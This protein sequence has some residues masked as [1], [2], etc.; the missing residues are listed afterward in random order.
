MDSTAGIWAFGAYLPRSRLERTAIAAATRWA[1]GARGGKA[2]GARSCC[3]WDEDSVT[4][5]VEAARDCL[6]GRGRGS[7]GS[8]T[9]A[10]TTLP[11]ADRSNAGIVAT[12]L[13]LD[14]STAVADVASCQR[15]GTSALLEALQRPGSAGDAL[16]LASDRRLARPGSDQEMNYGH[17]AAALLVG[18]GPGLLAE[19]LGH[20]TTMADFVD[21][22]RAD[23]THFDYVLEERWVRDAGYLQI[24]PRTVTRALAQAGLA[25]NQVR[26]FI[27]QGPRRFALDAAKASGI[28]AEAVV[29]D[30]HAHC[31]DTGTAHP[32]LLL[33]GAME[34][35][36]AGDLIVMAG[37]GQGCDALVLR[38]T[39]LGAASPSDHGVA[40]A[41]AR[42][43]A[44]GE[45]VRFLSNCG[46][47]EMDWGMRAERD[48]R[49]SQAAAWRRH[50]DVTAFVGGRCSACGTI[51]FPRSQACV[52]PDCR[53]FGTQ[54]DHPLA[55]STAHVK[56]FTEDWLA[57]TRAPPL[58]YGNVTF[59]VGGNLYTEFT[60]TLPGELA[61]GMPVRFAFR[62]KDFDS[63]RAFRR[64]AWKATPAR[65]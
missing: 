30:L 58:V 57:F 13:D 59:D 45:Y 12:A 43:L 7:I 6:A 47:V 33:A 17:G 54:E 42:G 50:R 64:Y 19:L 11:F 62:V 1:K 34:S 35:A 8:L 20:A 29:D 65:N 36:A 48:N 51:Q 55:E 49:T 22:H 14:E 56:T 16:V 44:D 28:P 5:A 39:G 21:H 24:V 32:L 15:A 18:R 4:M 26:H 3:N 27:A 41:L 25:T 10:S 38:A 2:A 61:I 53:A 46:L 23:G 60:D 40:A 9:L 31:G 52:N 37:F 63:T